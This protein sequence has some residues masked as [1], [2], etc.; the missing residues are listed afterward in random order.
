MR[1][2][3]KLQALL[4]Q[5]QVAVQARAQELPSGKIKAIKSRN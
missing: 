5:A 3:E 4:F 1:C 2:K